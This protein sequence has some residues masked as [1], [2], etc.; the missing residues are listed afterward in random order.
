MWFDTAFVPPP[1]V[2]QSAFFLGYPPL[3]V[4]KV[5]VWCKSD[6]RGS[7]EVMEEAHP[8]TRLSITLAYLLA[9]SRVSRYM[10]WGSNQSA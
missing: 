8:F 10:L 3:W 9:P 6:E 1:H 5:L 4:Y 7:N 2:D